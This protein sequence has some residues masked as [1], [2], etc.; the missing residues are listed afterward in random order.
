[1]SKLFLVGGA[2]ICLCSC[3]TLSHI[4]SDPVSMSANIPVSPADV[5]GEGANSRWVEAAPSDLP[6]TDWV[7]S[8]SDQRLNLLVERA[9]DANAD[10]RS[11]EARYRAALASVD[12]SEADLQPTIN[13][14]VGASRSEVF[15]S[16]VLDRT[17]LTGSVNGSWEFDLWG[18]IRDNVDSAR[19]EAGASQADYAGARLA[20]AAQV[21]QTWFNLIEARL[22]SELSINNVETQERAFSYA[23]RRFEGGVG[24]ESDLRLARSALANSQALQASRRQN[25]SALSRS[26]E[27][28]LREYPDEDLTAAP[29]LPSLPVLRGSGGPAYVLRHRPDLLAAERRMRAAGFNVDV[30]RKALLPSL[31]FNVGI[32]TNGT[33]FKNIFDVDSL[34]ANLAG[35]L[36]APIFQGGRLKANVVQQEEILR[37]QLERYSGT[38]LQAYLEVENALDAEVRLAER[39]AALRESLS[40]ASKAEERFEIRYSEGLS[41]IFNLLDSQTRRISVEGQLVNARKERL[42][43]RVR[44][45][46][47]PGGAISHKQLFFQPRKLF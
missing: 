20:I 23:V 15:E 31:S 44:L 5:A 40:E 33:A 38:V 32:N 27:V 11:A 37:Q 25:Q 4:K 47:A 1:M 17:G 46:V 26:L 42:T 41:T 22:L 45:Y 30:A 9:L 10:L 43:N 24:A 6:R 39:E 12:D 29:D 18:R 8:F 14:S 35:G 7:K 19:L 21:V 3:A 36:M 28:L 34:V 13:A 2:A 16:N